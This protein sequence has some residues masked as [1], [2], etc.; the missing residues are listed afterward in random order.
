MYARALPWAMFEEL[1]VVST[2]RHKTTKGSKYTHT[3]QHHKIRTITLLRAPPTAKPMPR[4]AA[5]KDEA[6]SCSSLIT[7]LFYKE[8]HNSTITVHS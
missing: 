1:V 4:P 2:D 7:H 3:L 8:K 5:I 6:V